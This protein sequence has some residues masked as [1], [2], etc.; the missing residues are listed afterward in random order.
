MMDVKYV[1]KLAKLNLDREVGKRMEEHFRRML[2]YVKILDELDLEG[3]EPLYYPHMGYQRMR[4][5]VPEEGLAR[6][7][8]LKDAPDSHLY[9]FRVPSPLKGVRKGK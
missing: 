5:D 3:V 2:E 4:R 1:A 8:A 6:D 9:F 7:E